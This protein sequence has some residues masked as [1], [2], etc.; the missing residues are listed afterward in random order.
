MALQR[1][2]DEERDIGHIPLSSA[3]SM[4]YD[5]ATSFFYVHIYTGAIA[6]S[7]IN[8]VGPTFYPDHYRL[9]GGILQRNE[10]SNTVILN[11]Q[12]GTITTTTVPTVRWDPS[13]LRSQWGSFRDRAPQTWSLKR[14][15]RS[16]WISFPA[17]KQLPAITK[18]NA[19]YP[20]GM[21]FCII[22]GL[23]GGLCSFL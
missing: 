12:Q 18:R 15:R 10:S 20:S 22:K 17:K 23:S 7:R 16:V 21:Y 9:R 11:M 8:P 6:S 5:E 2:D 1:S 13:I 19:N 3:V 14:I 4:L